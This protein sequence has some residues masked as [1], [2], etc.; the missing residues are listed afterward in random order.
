M[1]LGFFTQCSLLLVKDYWGTEQVNNKWWDPEACAWS[2]GQN[3]RCKWQGPAAGTCSRGQITSSGRTES[4][5]WMSSLWSV[6]LRDGLVTAEA[7]K[8]TRQSTGLG[9]F[10]LED[11]GKDSVFLFHSFPFIQGCKNCINVQKM[12]IYHVGT[13][14]FTCMNWLPRCLIYLVW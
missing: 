6:I 10:K 13:P 9:C 7:Q 8:R 14:A 11:V 12:Y 4:M 2:W 5:Y 1:D 3:H